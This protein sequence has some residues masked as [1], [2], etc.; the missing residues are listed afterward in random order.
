MQPK[1]KVK[2][3]GVLAAAMMAAFA[4]G[5]SARPALAAS[6]SEI[7]RNTTQALTTL[8][9]TTPGA[10]ALADKS[11]GILIFPSIV[12]GGLIVGAEYGDGAL[13]KSGKTV[14]YYRT[15]SGSFGLQAGVQSFGYVL[16]FMDD[17]SLKYLHKSQGWE[18]GTGPT[19]VVLDKGFAKNLSTTTLQTG[20]YAFVFDQKGLMAGISLQGSKV[21]RIHPD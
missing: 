8:Y 9:Q 14:G 3:R 1:D 20:V 21:T 12:K 17:A 18:L 11:R 2:L 16:F 6:K 4:Y 10:E 13:R 15:I 5:L 7:D 19:L